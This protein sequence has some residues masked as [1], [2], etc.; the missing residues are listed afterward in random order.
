MV[1][2]QTKHYSSKTQDRRHHHNADRLS[3]VIIFGVPES[4]LAETKAKIDKIFQHLNGESIRVRDIYRLGRRK[5]LVVKDGSSEVLME[6]FQ[7]KPSRPRPVL[8]KLESVW[9]RRLL[10]ANRRQLK[11]Y[12]AHKIFIREDIPLEIR[13]KNLKSSSAI[14]PSS[15]TLTQETPKQP[16]NEPTPMGAVD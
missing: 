6:D 16:I 10:L 13:L 7:E 4:S 2:S 12:T 5:D 1:K 15:H 9:D 3:N 11:T 8:V 14:P